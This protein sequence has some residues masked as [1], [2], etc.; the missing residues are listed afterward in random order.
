[1]TA[2][3]NSAAPRRAMPV[4]FLALGLGGL[5]LMGLPPSGGFAAKWLLMKASIEA[6]QWALGDRHGGRRIAGRRL[7]L[8]G[9]GPG[10]F[11]REPATEEGARAQPRK[12]RSGSGACR[13][14][15]RV[16]AADRS[17][18]SCR[19]AVRP[20]ASRCNERA[21]RSSS[22][23]ACWSRRSRRRSSFWPSFSRRDCARLARAITPLAAAARAR[24]RRARDWRRAVRRR[25]AC[26][27]RQPLARSAGRPA[28]RSR[29]RSSGSSSAS[30]LSGKGRGGRTPTASRSRGC[31][32]WPA[33][34]ACSSP[35]TF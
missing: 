19:S 28:A 22:V 12:H 15:A 10:A 29:R 34:S 13:R 33:V 17:S 1:M 2:S 3:P 30:S 23:P 7:S 4:T 18:P 14:P 31:S 20:R 6:G 16:R 11:G 27:A 9:A 8:P 26:V 32:R 35:P 5:S 24:R 21:R 25:A